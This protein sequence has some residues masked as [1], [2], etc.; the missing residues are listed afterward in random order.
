VIPALALAL[1]VAACSQSEQP[2]ALN[3]AGV[4]AGLPAEV[5]LAEVVVVASRSD[6]GAASTSVGSS[7]ENRDVELR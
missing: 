4:K 2:S 7:G 1:M 6:A 3:G 5:P